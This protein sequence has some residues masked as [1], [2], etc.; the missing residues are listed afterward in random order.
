M[1]QLDNVW[2]P[3]CFGVQANMPNPAMQIIVWVI[4]VIALQMA[5]PV[6]LIAAL[7]LLLVTASVFSSARFLLLLRRT[8]WIMF[9]LLLI[10]AFT[11]PGVAVFAF[12]G[13][14]SPTSE[15][16]Q[17]G[18]LQLGRLVS[19][20]ASL[21]ILL[22]RV[23]QQKLVGGLYALAYPLSMIGLARERIAVRLALTL[24]YAETAML[25]TAADWRGS[26]E[27]LL[28]PASGGQAG[29]EIPVV[30]FTRADVLL[31]VA[32]CAMLALVML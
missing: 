19:V 28:A 7:V 11:I 1:R 24:L 17:Q 5:G 8:R 13:E 22:S 14:Y 4:L 6:M 23:D 15:G 3:L 2:L 16:L 9:S 20:L 18:L 21:S 25:D 27:N 32:G 29:I 10:Y 31:L 12:L 26:M 30:R